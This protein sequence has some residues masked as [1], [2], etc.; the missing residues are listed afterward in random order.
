M[1]RFDDVNKQFKKVVLDFLYLNETRT[2]K[3]GLLNVN[4]KEFFQ[5]LK[6]LLVIAENNDLE[7]K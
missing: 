3:K 1:D 6:N 5:L 4:N 7:V 2:D